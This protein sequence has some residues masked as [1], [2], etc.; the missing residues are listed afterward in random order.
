MVWVVNREDGTR[1]RE[2]VGNHAFGFYF[3][4]SVEFRSCCFFLFFFFANT[5]SEF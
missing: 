4:L 1:M 3:I 2:R 5:F